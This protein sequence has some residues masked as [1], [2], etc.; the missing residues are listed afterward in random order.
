MAAALGLVGISADICINGRSEEALQAAREKVYYAASAANVTTVAVDLST[1][2]GCDELVDRVPDVDILVNNLRIY[3]PKAVFDT[4]NE[5][6]Q[7]MFDVTVMCGAAGRW[8]HRHQSF[9][10][11]EKSQYAKPAAYAFVGAEP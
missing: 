8:R 9:L 6:W 4:P 1:S 10:I 11:G 5:D 3:E 2:D 7:R